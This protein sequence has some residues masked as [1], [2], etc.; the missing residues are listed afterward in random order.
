VG[1]TRGPAATG[2][3]SISPG[4]IG[5]IDPASNSLTGQ[6]PVGSGPTS[7][8]VG[9]GGVWVGVAGERTL[10]RIDPQTKE[11]T[12]RLGLGRI[13]SQ[14][15]VANGT[16]W[17]ASAIG[18][19]GT[20]ANVD[21]RGAAVISTKTVR[22]GDEGDLFAPAT[23]SALAVGAGAVWT[24]R[25]RSKVARFAVHGGPVETLDLGSSHSADGIA[26]GAGAVW[27]ASSADD[28]LLRV[29]PSRNRVAA[30]IPIAARRGARVAGPYAVAVG[31]GSVWVTDALA[32][33]VSRVD[34]QLGAVTATIPVGRRPTRIAVGEGAV[35]VLNADDGT[36]TRIDPRTDEPVA[37]IHVGKGVTGIAAG[38]GAVWV[39]VGGGPAPS[40]AGSAVG[41]FTPLP[42][43]MCSR[44]YRGRR[45]PDLLIVSDLPTI[46]Y[47]ARSPVIRDMRAAIRFMLA[48]RGFRAGSYAIGYQEC[49]DSS[50]SE[51]QDDPER[52]A[53]N[54]RAYAA[55]AS[56][57]GIVG[58]YRSFCTALAL[59]TLNA[60]PGGPVATISPSNTYVGLTRAGP[61]TAADEPD[62]YYPTGVRNYARLV[63]ADHVQGAALALL[64]RELGLRRIYLLDDGEGTGY[65][66]RTYVADAARRLGLT[67]AGVGSWDA[68]ARTYAPLA[69][70]IRRRR[71]DGIVLTGCMCLNG[72]RLVRDLRR[73]LGRRVPLLGSD[74]FTSPDLGSERH[75]GTVDGVYV[76]FAGLPAE[77]ATE[78]GR[79]FLNRLAPERPATATDPH[80]L[81]AAQAVDLLLTA[82]ARSDGTRAS[83]ANELE[84]SRVRD[85]IVGTLALD[86]NGDPQPSPVGIY[87]IRARA[88]AYP[89]RTVKRLVLDRV[90][91][92]ARSL[93]DSGG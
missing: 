89:T 45:E 86:A 67:V 71:A 48:E 88:P 4:S 24:N 43:S 82:I 59:P 80:V 8:A 33:A 73:T 21:P 7:V 17:A 37:T 65:A 51:G 38:A 60:A 78:K 76:S 25:V 30:V 27:V 81:Y 44:V 55:N 46:L 92:P 15:T 39:A 12:A 58:P 32:D 66:M 31:H 50:R 1:L 52:C 41:R 87:R 34:P 91:Q 69:D 2:L 83:V 64:A 13:P 23:P 57:V 3:A 11:I 40:A 9:E 42:A 14:I 22:V 10:A 61:A 75:A 36:V 35:W 85:G 79:E 93:I 28:K 70:A 16:V 56:V 90:I 68:D 72:P 26:V 29:D 20:V 53:A 19:R 6:I 62:R 63:G 18:G 74:N 49:D 54:A 47:G 5:V 84:R 77:E